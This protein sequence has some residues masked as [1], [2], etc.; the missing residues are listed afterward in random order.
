[1]SGGGKLGLDDA[2]SVETPDDNI[3][4][5][6]E[7]AASYDDDFVAAN[8]YVLFHRVADALAR[9]QPDRDA[10]VL[11]VGCGTGVCG[12]ALHDIGFRN[13]DGVDISGAMLARAERKRA[14]D[15]SPIYRHLHEA[16]LSVSPTLSSSGY[17]GLMSAGTFTH[18]HLGPDALGFLWRLASSGAVAAI[19]VNARHYASAGFEAAFA[20]AAAEGDISVAEVTEVRMY[21]RPPP[22]LEPGNER[23]KIVICRVS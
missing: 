16:D 18:G 15:G 14:A 9:H 11:D 12:V 7:W 22:G 4:L 13:I 5:Y 3:R 17:G 19:G 23:A 6:A 21:E 8:G 20:A 10:A 1:M 2:Y